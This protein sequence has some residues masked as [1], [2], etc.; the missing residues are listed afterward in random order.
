[1][2]SY[3]RRRESQSFSSPSYSATR[4]S[5]SRDNISSPQLG[6]VSEERDSSSNQLY[7]TPITDGWDMGVATWGDGGSNEALMVQGGRDSGKRG[8]GRGSDSGIQS[9]VRRDELTSS[10]TSRTPAFS[11]PSHL[12]QRQMSAD[13]LSM[14]RVSP[15]S[16]SEEGEG[17]VW[18]VWVASSNAHHSTLSV[19]E[20]TH[21]FSSVE[22]RGV[23]SWDMF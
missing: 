5:G 16:V 6:M 15:F 19:L 8:S 20:Y 4:Q 7:P 13:D 23:W 1:M 2:S 22:V 14:K 18:E 17:P 10:L 3:L 9:A 12:L 11:S 21:S